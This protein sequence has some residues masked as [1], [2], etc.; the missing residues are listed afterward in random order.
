MT[1]DAVIIY[2]ENQQLPASLADWTTLSSIF[3]EEDRANISEMLCPTSTLPMSAVANKWQEALQ[4]HNKERGGDKVKNGNL[5]IQEA[6][7]LLTSIHALKP[8]LDEFLNNK[9]YVQHPS[10]QNQARYPSQSTDSAL[11]FLFGNACTEASSKLQS[12]YSSICNLEKNY[13]MDINSEDLARALH[14]LDVLS[15]QFF[16]LDRALRPCKLAWARAID[17]LSATNLSS[18]LQQLGLGMTLDAK[19][20]RDNREAEKH[21]LEWNLELV[22]PIKDH[23]NK[24]GRLMCE[25]GKWNIYLL[26]GSY[27]NI[28]KAVGN[29]LKTATSF[30]ENISV[31]LRC[32]VVRDVPKHLI[33]TNTESGTVIFPKDFLATISKSLKELAAAALSKTTDSTAT[34]TDG[35]T[36]GLF[37]CVHSFF[38]MFIII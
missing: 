16:G 14:L 31:T 28:T 22:S 4:E 25:D 5:S 18:V 3:T 38:Y 26:H 19:N 17:G 24:W 7:Q 30:E 10:E 37:F 34:A 21:Q 20:K 1:E 13:H 35:E 6:T 9:K 27:D 33:P 15:I 29:I 2:G 8:F 11:A 32:L 36:V 12:F 23:L